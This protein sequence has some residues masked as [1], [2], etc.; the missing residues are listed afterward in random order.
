MQPIP[1]PDVTALLHAWNEGDAREQVM[2]RDGHWLFVHSNRPGSF[3]PGSD[4]WVSCREHVHDDFAWEPP[5]NLG[6]GV[7]APGAVKSLIPDS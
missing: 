4:I 2:S 1:A 5:V 6:P 3:V 7:N